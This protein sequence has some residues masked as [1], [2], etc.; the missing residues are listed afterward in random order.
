MKIEQ[1]VLQTLKRFPEARN[2]DFILYAFT[3]ETLGYLEKIESYDFITFLVNAKKHKF[4]S[5]ETVTRARRKLQVIHEDLRHDEKTDKIRF[6]NQKEI[7][8]WL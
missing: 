7:L 5:F 6:E 3:I 8:N 1:A 4:P 2:N